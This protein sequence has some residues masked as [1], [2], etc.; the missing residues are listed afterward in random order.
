MTDD[1]LRGFRNRLDEVCGKQLSGI[2]LCVL[3]FSVATEVYSGH[4]VA[5]VSEGR[6]HGA[7]VARI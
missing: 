1:E 7:P 3:T 5:A 4:V 2:D 6:T